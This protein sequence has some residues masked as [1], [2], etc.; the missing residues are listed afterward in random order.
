MCGI[1][2]PVGATFCANC[3]TSLTGAPPPS[4]ARPGVSMSDS[5]NWA[6]G[7]HGSAIAGALLGGVASFVGPLIIWLIR[8]DTDAF[9]AQH[10]KEAL[11]FNLTTLLVVVAGWV[12]TVLT[13]GIGLIALAVFGVL[14]LVWSIQACMAAS[15]GEPYHYPWAIRFVT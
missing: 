2:S 1:A 8:K 4:T 12:I 14:W 9:S 5:Q 7:A 10:A 15:R 6:V 11:N 13:F 3:G